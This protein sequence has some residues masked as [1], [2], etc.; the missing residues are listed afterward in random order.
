MKHE[1][2]VQD[3]VSKLQKV[4]TA[5]DVPLVQIDDEEIDVDDEVSSHSSNR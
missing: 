2:V 4:W 5:K 1:E 3:V